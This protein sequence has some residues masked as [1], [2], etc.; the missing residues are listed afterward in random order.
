MS[1]K[2]VKQYLMLLTAIGLIAI[3]SGGSGTF[4]SFTAETANPGN[5]FATGTLYLHD[6]VT[7][8]TECTSESAT[9]NTNVPSTVAG[10]NP[11]N[12]CD[13]IFSVPN[14]QF[15]P[16]AL[17]D[18]TT[19]GGPLTGTVTSIPVLDWNGGSGGLMF[20]IPSGNEVQI[21]QGGNTDIC[22]ASGTA[23]A[24]ASSITVSSCT[25]GSSYT[26]GAV[27]SSFGPY[28]GH[29]TLRNAGTI[30]G[31]D[32]KF[33]FVGTGSSGA[34][35]S[36]PVTPGPSAATTLCSD[37]K[38][39]IVETNRDFAATI[40]STTGNITGAV[41]CAFGTSNGTGC[42]VGSDTLGSASST[43]FRTGV[44]NALATLTLGSG[45]G[46]NNTRDLTGVDSTVNHSTGSGPAAAGQTPGSA[47]Y[48]SSLTNPGGARY[49]LVEVWPGSLVNND[50]GASTVFDLVWHMDQA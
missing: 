2:R 1:R 20:S 14:S 4:A 30:D 34:D 13:Y 25:L 35:P 44:G 39:S 49:F 22:Q 5:T 28:I 36:C 12:A 17:F 45:T 6:S 11:G 16:N 32:L 31:K 8:N 7:N 38:F 47:G 37:L 3:A 42:D 19:N 10:S 50:M 9:N 46:T 18:Q 15:A 26:T 41:G 43:Y 48:H 21:S 29:L 33:Q 40:N 27:I 24:G 23:A